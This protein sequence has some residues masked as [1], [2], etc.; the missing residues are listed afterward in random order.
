MLDPLRD[1]MSKPVTFS[2]KPSQ[3]KPCLKYCDVKLLADGVMDEKQKAG[4]LAS[5]LRGPALNWLSQKRR[6]EPDITSDYGELQEQLR[7]TFAIDD[8][9][10][11]LQAARYSLVW[12]YAICFIY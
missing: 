11:R 1:D 8:E 3:L 7:A 6:T 12:I 9:S 10:Q 4:T 2:G 5:L